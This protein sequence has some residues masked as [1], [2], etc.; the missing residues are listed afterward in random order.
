MVRVILDDLLDL[1]LLIEMIDQRFVKEQRHPSEPLRILNYTAAA[2][3]DRVWNDVTRK[4]RGL[5]VHDNGRVVARPWPKFHNYGEHEEGTLD[6]TEH[7]EVT[8]KLDGSLGIMYPA[9]DRLAVA[10]RGSF[11]SDQAVFATDLL[12]TLYA[13]FKPWPELTYLFEIIYPANRIVVDYAGASDLFLLGATDTETGEGVPLDDLS[14][15]GPRTS[16]FPAVT[17]ADALALP[18][19]PNA[20]GIVV[21]LVRGTLVKVKQDDYVALHKLVTGL[22]ERTVW[23]HLATGGTAAE[24][25]EGLPDEFHAWVDDVAARLVAAHD[26]ELARAQDEHDLIVGAL[27]DGWTRKDYAI[28]ARRSPRAPLLFLLLDARDPSPAIWKT[29]KPEAFRTLL[30]VTEDVA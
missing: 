5:I 17:L 27:D 20:E 25:C 26:H 18:P 9:G 2:Q 12:Q 13:D 22:N 10:T 4:C 19:R 6:L 30:N 21:R 29:L 24:L 16:I 28:V 11:T 3:Y 15:K 14:W 23:E 7:C 8:D 1:P